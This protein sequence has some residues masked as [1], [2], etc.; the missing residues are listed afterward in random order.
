MLFDVNAHFRANGSY[1]I[2]LVENVTV[3]RRTFQPSACLLKYDPVNNT[4]I[5]MY[6]CL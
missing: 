3:R 2:S 6:V 5:Y 1:S 4:I